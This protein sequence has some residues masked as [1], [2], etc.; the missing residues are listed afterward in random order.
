MLCGEDK[1]AFSNLIFIIFL[2]THASEKKYVAENYS[3]C[4]H[5]A[6]MKEAKKKRQTKQK[7]INFVITQRRKWHKRR[8]ECEQHRQSMKKKFLLLNFFNNFKIWEIDKIF[9]IN[10][11]WMLNFS[12]Y[13]LWTRSDIKVEMATIGLV[14]VINLDTKN[15]LHSQVWRVKL[16]MIWQFYDDECAWRGKN[17]REIFHIYSMSVDAN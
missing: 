5:K 8:S 11:L 1:V 7:I 9:H 10:F 13:Q 14:F 6:I 4:F 16:K 17:V 3:I 15:I 2:L 12:L